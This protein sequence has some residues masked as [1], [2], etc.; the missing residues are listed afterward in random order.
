MRL[1]CDDLLT[2]AD[3]APSNILYVNFEDERLASF[4]SEDCERLMEAYY[5]LEAPQGSACRLRR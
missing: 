1:V 5:E 4:R 3:V 2:T